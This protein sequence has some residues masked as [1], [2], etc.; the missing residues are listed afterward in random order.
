MAADL[1]TAASDYSVPA[2]TSGPNWSARFGIAFDTYYADSSNV[3]AGWNFGG[4]IDSAVRY[5]TGNGLGAQFDFL[6]SAY[7]NND[8]DNDW[9]DGYLTGAAHLFTRNSVGLLGVI[10]GGGASYAEDSD[11]S[12]TFWFAGLEG[13]LAGANGSYMFA[14]GGYLDG[15]DEYDEGLNHAGFGRVGGRIF[16]QPNTAFMSAISGAV[17]QQDG[18]DAALANLELEV[19]QAI[20]NGSTSLFASYEGTV[21]W[22]HDYDATS[23]FQGVMLGVRW[24]PGTA[25][26]MA[27][28]QDGASLDLPSLGRWFSLTANEVEDD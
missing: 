11:E 26:L 19:E 13:T 5:D 7:G 14:Q 12:Q 2:E 17:G 18:E 27:A 22:H 8:D 21:I 20:G 25:D 1:Y 24:R 6:G 3:D 4:N 9:T 28:Y 23:N 15:E 16:L 10:A